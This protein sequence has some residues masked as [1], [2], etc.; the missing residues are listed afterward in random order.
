VVEKLSA[1]IVKIMALPEVKSRLEK[2]GL[3]IR[4][5]T[6]TQFSAYIASEL[7]RWEKVVK[8]SGATLD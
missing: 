3:E 4:T 2:D 6:A 7:P 5:R 1:E 8:E